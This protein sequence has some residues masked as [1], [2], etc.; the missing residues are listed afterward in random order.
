MKLVVDFSRLNTS[1]L[2]ARRQMQ[3][4]RNTNNHGLQPSA[5]SLQPPEGHRRLLSNFNGIAYCQPTGQQPSQQ[6]SIST[7]QN[8]QLQEHDDD[9]SSIADEDL[10][11]PRPSSSDEE[12][13]SPRGAEST[14]NHCPAA[15]AAA[16][17]ANSMIASSAL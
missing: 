3:T 9:V 14:A 13:E 2:A 8:V 7:R 6:A 1:L 5:P 16:N 4:S 12:S 10:D 15:A 17:P 11:I